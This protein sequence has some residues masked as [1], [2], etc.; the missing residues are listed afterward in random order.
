MASH[1][2]KAAARSNMRKAVAADRQKH[3]LAHL[4]PGAR[5]ALGKRGVKMPRRKRPHNGA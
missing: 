4:P 2:K 5:P 1:R 3:T